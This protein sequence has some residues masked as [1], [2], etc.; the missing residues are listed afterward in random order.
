[1]KKLIKNYKAKN[2]ASRL[3][4]LKEIKTILLHE[5]QCVENLIEELEQ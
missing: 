3:R 1:M 2:R 5:L 4:K